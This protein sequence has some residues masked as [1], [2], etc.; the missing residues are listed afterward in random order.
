MWLNTRYLKKWPWLL[1][2]GPNWLIECIEDRIG[3]RRMPYLFL[4]PNLMIFA[5]FA[6]VPVLLNFA[7]SF[8]SGMSILPGERPFVGL[9]NFEQL[10]TCQNYL[11]FRTCTEDYFWRAAS[12][13]ARFVLLEVPSLVIMALV[14]AVALNRRVVLRGFFR[15]AFFY[16]V[17]LSPV[18]VAL[19]WKW[20]LQERGGLLNAIL[21]R[22]GL[23]EVSFLVDPGWMFFWTVFVSI[24]AQVGFYA[25]ILLAGLQSIPAVLYEAATIDGASELTSFRRI[26]MP[27]LMPTMLVVVVLA[28]I[29]GVQAFDHV[30]VLTGGGPGTATVMMVQ[31]IYRTG[32]EFRNYG[33]AASASLVMASVLAALTL[34][35]LV[36]E[37]RKSIDQD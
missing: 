33:L 29:R 9:Q 23:N 13:T 4:L 22:V 30:F 19:I 17:L 1:F 6:F 8:T 18:V 28:L 14:V 16:P 11:D 7:F 2:N 20:I 32:F 5:V 21:A 37:R 26:T 15:S 10:A 3:H 27:L 24:W 34:V 25:L 35:R 12:N 36:V 31:Y